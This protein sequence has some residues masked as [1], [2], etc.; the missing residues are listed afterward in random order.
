MLYPQ[1]LI[2]TKPKTK[3]DQGYYIHSHHSHLL[4]ASVGF[5]SLLPKFTVTRLCSA[6]VEI[7]KGSA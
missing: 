4:A 3:G 7:S 5:A 1:Y 2:L 6:T